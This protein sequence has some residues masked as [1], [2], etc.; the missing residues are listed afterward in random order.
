MKV[1]Q[2]YLQNDH[3]PIELY[4]QFG[5]GSSLMC[6]GGLSPLED[7]WYHYNFVYDEG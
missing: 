6:K 1:K 4:V 5:K 2:L 7:Q 3:E